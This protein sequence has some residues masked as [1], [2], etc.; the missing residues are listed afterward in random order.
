MLNPFRYEA[1]LEP[2]DLIGR[3]EVVDRVVQLARDARVMTLAAPRRYG[4]TSI[5]RAAGRRLADDDAIVVYVDLLGLID[6]EDLAQRFAAAWQHAVSGD[7]RLRAGAQRLL[8]GLADVGISVLGSGVTVSRRVATD[9]A[10]I[11]ALHQLLDLPSAAAQKGRAV[12]VVLDEFQALHAAWAEGE[13]LLRSHTQ[14]PAAV[15]KVAWAFAGSQRSLLAAAFSDAGRA[16]YQQA[17]PVAVERL[18]DR[19]LAEGIA[20][21]F[22]ASDRD[23][24][25]ALQ[26][27]VGIADG[28]PQRA[29]LLTHNLHDVTPRGAPATAQLWERALSRTR[30]Q[31][32]DEAAAV[33]ESLTPAQQAALRSIAGFGTT[34]AAPARRSAVSRASRQSALDPLVRRGLVEADPRAPGAAARWRV[35]DPLLAD[36]VDLRTRRS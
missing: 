17:V 2:A 16:F 23:A 31:V 4:K 11:A 19:D 3:E 32:A 24:G 7:R 6:A 25:A 8:A 21:R 18:T 28:H 20:A 22:A 14:A 1:P 13:G 35:V 10:V 36:W 29:M 9:Q 27:L 15:W 30:L 26:P 12:L 5:L 34:T 33:W